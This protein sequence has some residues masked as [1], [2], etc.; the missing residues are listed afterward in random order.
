[1]WVGNCDSA[2][3]VC[4]SEV[5]SIKPGAVDVKKDKEKG[6]FPKTKLDAEELVCSYRKL[7]LCLKL[8]SGLCCAATG[9]EEAQ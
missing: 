4:N 7:K 6:M 8:T 9:K 3:S 5:L 2:T 1:M